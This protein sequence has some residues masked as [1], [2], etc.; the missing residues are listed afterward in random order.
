MKKKI[1]TRYFQTLNNLTSKVQTKFEYTQPPDVSIIISEMGQG[2]ASFPLFSCQRDRFTGSEPIYD[3][4]PNWVADCVINVRI[5]VTIVNSYSQDAHRLKKKESAFI[6]LH[7]TS[8]YQHYLLGNTLLFIK[9]NYIKSNNKLNANRLLRVRKVV[10]FVIS[11]LKLPVEA[12]VDPTSIV[13]ITCNSK[14]LY[15]FFM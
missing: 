11:K 8:R 15:C 2:G 14:V 1:Q 9:T 12:N 6:W 13:Q 4:I 10:T 3:A 5:L 7:L